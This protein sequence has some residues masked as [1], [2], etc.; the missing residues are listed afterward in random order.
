MSHSGVSAPPTA[1][2][3]FGSCSA[4]VVGGIAVGGSVFCSQTIPDIVRKPS[5][6]VV[7]PEGQVPRRE[8]DPR[9]AR[10]ALPP[11]PVL[12]RLC[13]RRLGNVVQGPDW[14]RHETAQQLVLALGA[15]FESLESR[16]DAMLDA[17][18]VAQFE[19]QAVMVAGSAPVA[20]VQR[21][22]TLQ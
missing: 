11:D 8:I 20:A 10:G 6:D 19:V 2:R 7:A 1:S 13:E 16:P 17:A 12:D 5:G 22:G 4:R 21:A 14:R 9:T 3:P 18:V 15:G